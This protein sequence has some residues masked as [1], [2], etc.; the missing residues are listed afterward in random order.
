MT[1]EAKKA[2]KT[3]KS[4]VVEAVQMTSE[5]LPS[6]RFSV[7]L[8]NLK[9]DPKQVRRYQSQAGLTELKALIASQGLLQNLTVRPA[10][11]AGEFYVT[12]GNRRLRSLNELV[13]DGTPVGPEQII[14]SQEFDVPVLE[15]L[16]SQSAVEVSLAENIG[17]EN[18]HPA[19]MIEAFGQLQ[20]ESMSCEEISDRFGISVMTVRRRLK[21]AKL[22]P[23]LIEIYRAGEATLEQL[24]ALA[25]SDDH[26]EQE[27]AFFNADSYSKSP[28]ELKQ[29]LTSE[30][31]S[32][33]SRIAKFVTAEAYEQAGGAI[34]RDLFNE[35]GSSGYLSDKPLLLKLALDQLQAER[36][37]IEL[38]GWKWVSVSLEQ[39]QQ[40]PAKIYPKTVA[41]SDIDQARQS[42]LAEKFD[43]LADACDGIDEESVEGMDLLAQRDAID[44]ELNILAAKGEAYDA[45]EM[46]Y[47]GTLITINYNGELL[48]ERGVVAQDDVQALSTHRQNL[49]RIAAGE[50]PIAA[51]FEQ[52]EETEPKQLEITEASPALSQAVIEDLTKL[53]TA[54]LGVEIAH[55]PDVALACTVHSLANGMFFGRTSA[56]TPSAIEL[57]A[58]PVNLTPCIED[59][60]NSAALSALSDVEEEWRRIMPTQSADLWHWCLKASQDTLLSLLAYC[61]GRSAN[62]ITQR[63]ESGGYYASRFTHADQIADAVGLDMRQWWKPS[64]GF[65]KRVPKAVAIAAMHETGVSENLAKA[66]EKETKGNAIL[67]A[68]RHLQGK[69]WLPAILRQSKP[70]EPK[71]QTETAQ[72]QSVD[73]FDVND[74]DQS[75]V[76]DQSQDAAEHSLA[77]GELEE[78]EQGGASADF[79]GEKEAHDTAVAD[80]TKALNADE[81]RAVQVEA[82]E[83]ARSEVDQDN[84]GD[85]LETT[86]AVYSPALAVFFEGAPNSRVMSDTELEALDIS[87]AAEPDAELAAGAFQQ[88]AE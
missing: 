45:G 5:A 39:P 34:V 81:D 61:V 80:Q 62:A 38:E 71:Q 13:K 24:Q 44:E 30:L 20:N 58:G 57:L 70:V 35:D 15:I 27:D 50:Q 79:A 84:E 67:V 68:E 36:P 4:A 53:R 31:V 26:A 23:K 3:A 73:E 29:R 85:R 19:D 10:E 40:A 43:E 83:T 59:P 87:H 42:E 63:H 46:A 75:Q 65:L 54:A 82:G 12:A 66:I 6:R 49:R 11:I 1:I 52:D 28:R 55:R 16:A 33:N 74:D 41:L 76:H 37:A 8:G 51:Q 48:I 22:S 25:I 86:I 88:A 17:R 18:M 2:T 60:D 72:A 69:G 32:P 14:A 7:K 77:E 56:A 64:L 9:P 78:I 21:L 47:A